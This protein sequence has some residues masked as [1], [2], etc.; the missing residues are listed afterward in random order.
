MGL[1]IHCRMQILANHTLRIENVEASDAGMYICTAE[2]VLGSDEAVARLKVERKFSFKQ[3]TYDISNTDVS[4]IKNIKQYGWDTFLVFFTFRIL[5]NFK[6]LV[7][8]CKFYSPEK[9]FELS[10]VCKKFDFEI[11]KIDFEI[12]SFWRYLKL[13]NDVISKGQYLNVLGCDTQ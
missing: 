13:R 6:L 2:N 10:V 3:L 7:S 9:Y 8:Q 4:Y 11:S 1:C 12:R 5:S